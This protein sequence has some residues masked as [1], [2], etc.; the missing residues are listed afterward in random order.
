[1][2]MK[3]YL[4]RV[5]RSLRVSSFVGTSYMY[6]EAR[7]EGSTHQ[8]HFMVLKSVKIDTDQK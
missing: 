8:K 3:H 6:A 2:I 4:D 7:S 5:K 1:M